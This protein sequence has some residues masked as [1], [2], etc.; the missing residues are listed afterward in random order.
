MDP[1]GEQNMSLSPA[2]VQFFQF[3]PS[4]SKDLTWWSLLHIYVLDLDIK[5]NTVMLNFNRAEYVRESGWGSFISAVG[6]WVRGPTE[7]YV[8]RLLGQQSSSDLSLRQ[9][10]VDLPQPTTLESDFTNSTV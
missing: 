8:S 3:L 6:L 2:A 1:R 5:C 9:L 10:K 4:W 7:T